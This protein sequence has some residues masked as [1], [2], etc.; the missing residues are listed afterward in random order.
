MDVFDSCQGLM[1]SALL[2]VAEALSFAGQD[3]MAMSFAQEAQ[4]YAETLQRTVPDQFET[5]VEMFP[6]REA[7]LLEGLSGLVGRL[8]Q[9]EGGKREEGR[10]RREEREEGGYWACEVD[11]VIARCKSPLQW[12]WE[13]DYPA[14]SRIFVYDKCNRGLADFRDQTSGLEGILSSLEYHQVAEASDEVMTGECTAYLAHLTK[15]VQPADFT[16]FLHDD[17]PRHIRLPLLSLVLRALRAGTYEEQEQ[18]Y[19]ASMTAAPDILHAIDARFDELEETASGVERVEWSGGL[20]K[21]EEMMT[22]MSQ[23]FRGDLKGPQ[24][25]NA[26]IVPPDDVVGMKDEVDNAE[27]KLHVGNDTPKSEKSTKSHVSKITEFSRR[28]TSDITEELLDTQTKEY[29]TWGIPA[30]VS[31]ECGESTWDLVIFIGTGALG[32]AGSFQTFLLAVINVLMQVVFCAIAPLGEYFNFIEPDIDSTAIED[33]KRWRRSSGHALSEY[34]AT[35]KLSLTQRVCDLDKSLHIS[36]TQLALLETLGRSGLSCRPR[37]LRKY[38]NS[39]KEGLA[40]FF[41]GEVLCVVALICWYLMV[42]KEVSH[43]LALHRGVMAVERG[44]T[45]PEPRRLLEDAFFQR[46]LYRATHYRLRAMGLRIASG[47]L[48][49]YR[50]VAA[51][52]LVFVG[53]FF[54]VY[55]AP[56]PYL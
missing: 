23:G 37:N 24:I 12:L 54:L 34:D 48:L 32:P 2:L 8:G 4:L 9:E 33:A 41:T 6:I 16:I 5:M 53:T 52:L 3:A 22:R 15:G 31:S 26:P 11:V 13:L 44:P 28:K 39:E 40:S 43:A 36:G 17:A 19:D 14:G 29:Y 18:D 10:G 46:D 25:A 35:S 49:A 50:L 7:G 30:P 51:A 1:A 20:A 45:R 38:L 42:A 47:L 21:L 56:L 27:K 55:T